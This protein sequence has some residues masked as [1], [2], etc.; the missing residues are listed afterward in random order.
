MSLIFDN[1]KPRDVV[2]FGRATVDLYANGFGPM[3]DAVTFSKYVGG[4][5]A[6]TSVAMANLGLKVGY[7]GKVSSDGFGRFVIKYMGG[8]GIDTSHI[9]YDKTG[10]R[11]GVTIGEFKSPAECSCFMYRKDCADLQISCS[12]LDE[13]YIASHRMLLISGTS[14]THAPA[15]EAVFLA[16]EYARRNGVR[17]AFDLDYRDDTWDTS[18]EASIYF[19][20]A[21]QKADMVLGTRS[22][23]DVMEHSFIN[24]NR[25]NGLSAK[26]LLDAGVSIVS[27]KRGK[28]GST[29]YT[30]GG[31]VFAGGI[32]PAKVDNTFGAG[33]SY[34]GAFN[35]S[36]INGKAIPEALKYAAASAAIT[37]SGH[38][39]SEAMPNLTQIEDYIATHE[40]IVK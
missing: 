25:D 17:I 16:M 1:S 36:L 40:Y 26:R 28:D 34:S 21:A 4:S 12:Q 24:G 20:L 37:V 3:E 30:R 23:F 6:N 33:D 2:A 15:R 10:A 18:E 31:Q 7:I 27:I 35:Y 22:E 14:L 5:P 11:S 38:S 8:K 39:C 29:V 32:Y 13:A 19:T 9:E